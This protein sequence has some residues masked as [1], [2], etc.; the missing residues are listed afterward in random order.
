VRYE[1]DCQILSE[2][3]CE[4]WREIYNVLQYKSDYF[5][6]VFYA[7][8]VKNEDE[9]LNAEREIQSSPLLKKLS[10]Y[11]VESKLCNKFGTEKKQKKGKKGYFLS[12]NWYI[13][14]TTKESI[15]ILK[16][17]KTLFYEDD[18]IGQADMYFMKG[19]KIVL[20][21]IQHESYCYADRQIL[22]EIK[23]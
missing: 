13:Y 18:Y 2:E 22:E 19:N 10:N 4:K 21:T 5:A 9:N 17:V 8:K 1:N 6:F 15:R 14:R 3:L 12:D 16:Q 11:F 23:K 7:A 20:F